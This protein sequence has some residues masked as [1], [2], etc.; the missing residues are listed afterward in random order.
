MLTL[1]SHERSLQPDFL[2]KSSLGLPLGSRLIALSSRYLDQRSKDMMLLDKLTAIGRLVDHHYRSDPARCKAN[3]VNKTDIAV[4]AR[5][6]AEVLDKYWNFESRTSTCLGVDEYCQQQVGPIISD[7]DAWGGLIAEQVTLRFS[8]FV[9]AALQS[10]GVGSFEANMSDA[11]RVAK[12]VSAKDIYITS[13]Y[14]DALERVESERLRVCKAIKYGCPKLSGTPLLT[15]DDLKDP[16]KELEHLS[17]WA[18]EEA[19]EPGTWRRAR[20]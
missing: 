12:S 16:P 2:C 6:L 13:G 15:K 7:V 19:S 4:A 9:K 17:K 11:A 14:I 20:R 8:G 1:T 5:P 3:I 18:S 10:K